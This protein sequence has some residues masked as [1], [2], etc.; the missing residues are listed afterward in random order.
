M[1]TVQPT[2]NI[3]AMQGLST[4]VDTLIETGQWDEQAWNAALDEAAQYANGVNGARDWLLSE[5][6]DEGWLERRTQLA[7][8][9]VA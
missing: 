3:K 8:P 2:I 4:R 6:L 7:K 9:R 5:A 1:A